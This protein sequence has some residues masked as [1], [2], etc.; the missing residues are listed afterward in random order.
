MAISKKGMRKLNVNG[1]SYLWKF[2]EKVFVVKD[3][4]KNNPLVIDIGWLDDWLYMNDPKI[5]PSENMPKRVTPKFVRESILFAEKYGWP[6]S[7]MEITCRN[8]SFAVK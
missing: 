5:D 3:M 6:E 8:G 1:N 2:K 4:H 7:K